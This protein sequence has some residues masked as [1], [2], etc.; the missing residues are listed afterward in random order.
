MKFWDA[1]AVIPLFLEEPETPRML[2]IARLDGGIVAW[3]GTTVVECRSAIA[4]LRR[5]AILTT[6]QEDQAIRLLAVLAEAW[7]EVRPGEAMRDMA[8]R[9]LQ[10]I[11]QER[12]TT[13]DSL[14]PVLRTQTTSVWPFFYS[15]VNS[16]SSGDI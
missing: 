8:G 7:A 2:E 1:S 3:W 6:S 11:N 13:Y 14:L 5:E 16:S 10:T 9:L 4:R 15:T 12:F